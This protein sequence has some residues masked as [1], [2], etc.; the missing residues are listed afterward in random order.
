MNEKDLQVKSSFLRIGIWVGDGENLDSNGASSYC[1]AVMNGVLKKK[2]SGVEIYFISTSKQSKNDAFPTIALN[3]SYSRFIHS[4]FISVSRVI[5]FSPIFRL[6]GKFKSFLEKSYYRSIIELS[7]KID[8]IYYPVPVKDILPDFPFIFTVWDLGHFNTY[9][10]PELS[11]NYA[12]ETRMGFYKNNLYKALIIFSE[13]DYGKKQ[14]SQ[15][16]NI[17]PD[18][19]YVLP[20]LASNVVDIKTQEQKPDIIS[21]NCRFIHYPAH[22]WAH[23]NHINLIRG[24][25]DVLGDYPELKLILSGLDKGV[26]THVENYI[27]SCDLWQNIIL[28]D[29][30]TLQELKWV[31]LNSSAL[32]YPSF[33]GPSNMPL[34]EAK[35]LNCPVVC[36]NLEGHIEQLGNYAQ[37]FDPKYPSQISEAIL[38]ILRSE[39]TDLNLSDVVSSELF[40]NSFNN[41][42]KEIQAVRITW[43]S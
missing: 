43:A 33:L 11:M 7:E 9:P 25:R 39:R 14:L 8:V 16:L 2:L 19:I 21:D 42:I 15:Y 31:Y 17:F 22:F 38:K 6:F 12:F 26:K 23:K 1:N 34:V 3:F 4:L 18:K 29:R 35:E 24:F 37:Y 20:M 10:F 5:E 13:S 28:T 41:A 32:V 36:S 27:T 30:F 40:I